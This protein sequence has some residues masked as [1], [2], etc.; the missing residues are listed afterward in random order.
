[1]VG[2]DF[3]N[4][5]LNLGFV[6]KITLSLVFDINVST[7]GIEPIVSPNEFDLRSIKI[8]FI[9]FYLKDD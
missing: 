4:K 8:V 3:V 1:M 6:L 9:I 2:Y 5:E 7:H